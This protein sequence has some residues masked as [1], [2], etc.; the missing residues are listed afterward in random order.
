MLQ[1]IYKVK[2]HMAFASLPDDVKQMIDA[3]LLG[4]PAEAA[5]GEK[6]EEGT[7]TPDSDANE[8]TQGEMP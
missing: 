4:L 6:T 8:S 2:E 5:T 1:A 3:I 7:P